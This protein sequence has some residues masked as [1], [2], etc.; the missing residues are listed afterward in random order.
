MLRMALW[1]ICVYGAMLAPALPER[2][3]SYTAEWLPRQSKCQDSERA[4][5]GASMIG[6]KPCARAMSQNLASVTPIE[7]RS[8]SIARPASCILPPGGGLNAVFLP[9][10]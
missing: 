9:E 10:T 8:M 1:A 5:S 2:T 6:K 4:G 7:E 3:Y